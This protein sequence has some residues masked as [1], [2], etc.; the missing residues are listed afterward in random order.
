[1]KK[2]ILLISSLFTVSVL[3]IVLSSCKDDEPKAKNV[4]AFTASSKT[5]QESVG[6]FEITVELN[7]AAPKDLI[8]QYDLLG[9]AKEKVGITAGDYEITSDPGEIKIAKGET[10]GTVELAIL[11]DNSYEKDETIILELTE[12]NSDDADISPDKGQIEITITNDDANPI[13]SFVNATL[14]VNEDD[15]LNDYIELEVVLDQPAAQDLTVNYKIDTTKISGGAIDSVWAHNHGISEYA[16]YFVNSVING[17]TGAVT[18]ASGKSSAKIQVQLFTDLYFEDDENIILTLTAN[19]DIHINDDKK[20]TTVTVKQQDG[21]RILLSWQDTNTDMD[22]IL[23][24]GSNVSSLVRPIAGS[25][26][27]NI[28]WEIYNETLFIPKAITSGVFGLTFNYYSGTV[29][30]LDFKVE[31]ADFTDGVLAAP[32]NEYNATYT[33]ENINAWKTTG[34]LQIEQTFKVTA[35]EITE[36]SAIT[37]PTSGSRLPSKPVST[38]IKKHRLSKSTY[39]KLGFQ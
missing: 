15:G 23:W 24:T 29:N 7:S 21:K 9:T 25:Q 27:D 5:V 37:I 2:S 34:D 31:Y 4:L 39:Q 8:I 3:S 33:K 13:A 11:N 36:I 30:P 12:L 20:T 22:M 16:D 19:D 6:T 35:S 32:S 18:V 10:T 28:T 17:I 26:I 1:M 14:T 38:K